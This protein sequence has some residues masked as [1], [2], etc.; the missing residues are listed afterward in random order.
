MEFLE[1]VF[2]RKSVQAAWSVELGE[3]RELQWRGVDAAG[4][5]LTTDDE[6]G[7]TWKDRAAIAVISRLPIEWL[8]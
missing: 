7:S 2:D 6:P 8:M 5:E 3:K 1:A 4:G